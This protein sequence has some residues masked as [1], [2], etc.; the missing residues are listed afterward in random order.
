[1]IQP[2]QYLYELIFVDEN[3]VEVIICL[4]EALN[5]K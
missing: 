3:V 2:V 4:N 5:H 1:M